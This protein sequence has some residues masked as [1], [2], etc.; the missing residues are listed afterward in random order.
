MIDRYDKDPNLFMGLKA[1]GS[2]GYFITCDFVIPPELARLTDCMPLAIFNSSKIKPSPYTTSIGGAKASQ[3]KLIA[4][5]HG[6]QRY[7]FHIKLL[8][9]YMRVGVIITKIHSVIEFSQDAIFK[10][11]VTHCADKRSEAKLNNDPNRTRT[12]KLLPNSLYGKTLQ[13]DIGYSGTSKLVLDGDRYR[14][15]CSNFRFKSRKWIVKDKI[16]LVVLK[17]DR[18]VVKTPIFIGTCVLQLAKLTNLSFEMQVLKAS[19]SNFSGLYPIRPTDRTIIEQS[20]KIIKSIIIIYMDTDSLLIFITL[21]EYAKDF[22]HEDLFKYTFLHK[23]LDRSNFNVLSTRSQCVPGQFGY[24]K[25]EVSDN[26]IVEVCALAPKL[27]SVR[28]LDRSCASKFDTKTAVKG[29]PNRVAQA[30]YSHQTFL[31]MLFKEGFMAPLARSNHIRR[32]KK[33][34]GIINTAMVKNCLS[35]IENKRYWFS[36]NESVGY[37]HPDIPKDGYYQPGD[38]LAARGATIVGSIP[39]DRNLFDN[40]N[41]LSISNSNNNNNDGVNTATVN[42]VHQTPNTLNDS[43]DAHPDFYDDD[44]DCDMYYECQEYDLCADTKNHDIEPGHKSINLLVDADDVRM[45][46]N[47]FIL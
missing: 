16:A 27:Y 38:I 45:N 5:H 24:L 47:P 7:S 17:K 21:T 28:S 30:T 34:S 15:L 35:L 4:S 26:V 36:W 22:T 8:Q 40:I 2:K 25:S 13:N 33:G 43:Y 1:E 39:S 31:D 42:F 12:Y 41:T 18:I 37:N 6:L 11:Y 32:D 20:R 23:Y 3:N 10:G 29:C 14:K 9:F 19:C 44:E 46:K